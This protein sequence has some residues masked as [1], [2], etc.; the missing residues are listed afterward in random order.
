MKRTT[1]IAVACL[2]AA[3][4]GDDSSQDDIDDRVY[5]VYLD[6]VDKSAEDAPGSRDEILELTDN[7]CDMEADSIELASFLDN[8]DPDALVLA[9]RLTAEQCPEKQ[10]LFR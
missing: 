5:E 1:L 7:M 4:G 9:R 8:S 2:L 6:H 3:C 10:D